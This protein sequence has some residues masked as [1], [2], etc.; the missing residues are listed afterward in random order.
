[1][2]LHW[3]VFRLEHLFEP[4][5]GRFPILAGHFIDGAAVPDAIAKF[6]KLSESGCKPFPC[7]EP[8]LA[9]F[10]PH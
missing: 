7:P 3:A 4:K 8:T 10:S 9:L 5:E 1:M 6:G 2:G